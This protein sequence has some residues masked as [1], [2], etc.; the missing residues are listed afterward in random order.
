MEAPPIGVSSLFREFY[1]ILLLYFEGIDIPVD[2]ATIKEVLK[3]LNVSNIRY[4]DKS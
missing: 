4:M 2:V 3:V 1:G